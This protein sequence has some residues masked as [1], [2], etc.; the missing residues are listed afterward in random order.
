MKSFIKII[1]TVF[2]AWISFSDALS[3][4]FNGNGTSSDPF[5][6]KTVQNL[7]ELSDSVN[8]GNSCD[9]LYFLQ[10]ENILMP[11]DS[12][13]WI[14][15]GS[16]KNKFQGIYD[17]NGKSIHNLFLNTTPSSQCGLFGCLGQYGKIK[18][19]TIDNIRSLGIHSIAGSVCAINEGI[20]ENCSSKNGSLTCNKLTGGIVGLNIGKVESCVNYNKIYGNYLIGGIVGYNYGEVS[21]C[22]NSGRI[23]GDNG[24]GGIVGYNGGFNGGYFCRD[25]V[26]FMFS[27]ITSCINTA[28]IYGE[29]YTGGI[30]GRNDGTLTL[31][32][33][34]GNIFSDEYAGG[35]AGANGNTND[36]ASLIR[37][38]INRG[39]VN[40]SKNMSAGISGFNLENGTIVDAVNLGNVFIADIETG[41]SLV[42]INEGFVGNSYWIENSSE[43]VYSNYGTIDSIFCFDYCNNMIDSSM[44]FSKVDSLFYLFGDTL[45]PVDCNKH[46]YQ[47]YISDSHLNDSAFFDI[48]YRY[49]EYYAISD[50][51][52]I[53]EIYDGIGRFV[54]K[55]SIDRYLPRKLTLKKGIYII[56]GKK[57]IIY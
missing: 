4:S 8:N 20:V 19:L 30:T 35:I 50:I 17:G 57:Q 38:C 28:K 27:T 1:F 46:I 37:Y 42:Y 18:N 22:N 12:T 29:F 51:G 54:Q 47:D 10:E 5:K 44:S 36:V 43:P 33:N 23:G 3:F 48:V 25:S 2:L 16:L 7:R 32:M 34:Y 55:F 40:A 45:L 13:G 21:N 39:D 56:N 52:Q 26:E 53:V 9:N 41:N 24:A 6:I 15:I 49:G 31:C 14:A 11:L